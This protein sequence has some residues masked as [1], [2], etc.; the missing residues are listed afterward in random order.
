MPFLVTYRPAVLLFFFIRQPV[1]AASIVGMFAL[2]EADRNLGL[3][4]RDSFNEWR[5]NQLGFATVTTQYEA[6][7]R[8]DEAKRN[9]M[10]LKQ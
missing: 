5:Q 10:L 6:F 7:K 9:E 1:A 3:G 2:W 8:I 4:I